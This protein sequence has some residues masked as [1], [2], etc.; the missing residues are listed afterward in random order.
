[1]GGVAAAVWYVCGKWSIIYTFISYYHLYTLH[2]GEYMR[3]LRCILYDKNL[4]QGWET[5][6]GEIE[7]EQQYK[8]VIRE[9]NYKSE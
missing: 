8:S 7:A 9:L 4:M 5:A 2:I 3:T 6:G 1:M